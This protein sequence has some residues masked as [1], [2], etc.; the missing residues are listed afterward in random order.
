MST[1]TGSAA[2]L[3]RN[4]HVASVKRTAR[5]VD[6][7]T[8]TEVNNNVLREIDHAA[9]AFDITAGTTPELAHLEP[10]VGSHY[11][12]SGTVLVVTPRCS[13]PPSLEPASAIY[14]R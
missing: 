8:G 2:K 10:L 5:V 13:T 9:A 3:A 7:A 12:R 11:K 4:M 6:S 14:R 1:P